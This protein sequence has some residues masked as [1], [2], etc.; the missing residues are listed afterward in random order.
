MF[1]FDYPTPTLPLEDDDDD[2]PV[3]PGLGYCV[4][5]VLTSSLGIAIDVP[6]LINRFPYIDY[7]PKKFA[8][9]TNRFLHPRITCLLFPSGKAVI[10]GAK[11]IYAALY[12]ILRYAAMVREEYPLAKVRELKVQ[13][14]TCTYDLNRIIDLRACAEQHPARCVFTGEVFAGMRVTPGLGT[15]KQLVFDT[16]N[17]VVTG[18]LSVEEA[19]KSLQIML[20]IYTRNSH[21]RGSEAGEALLLEN[22][23]MSKRTGKRVLAPP[24]AA[25]ET[26]DEIERIMNEV[27]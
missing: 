22:K 10:C 21:E 27:L 20:D 16:G 11:N 14:L 2:E 18:C 19:M 7:V 24:A 6:R 5:I 13:N 3:R 9:A 25:G 4:N 1:H 8:A 23:R 26:D 17:I 12:V 15:V